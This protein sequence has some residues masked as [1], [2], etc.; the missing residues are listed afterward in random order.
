M[1]GDTIRIYGAREHN[2]KDVNLE[3][4]RNAL[5]VFCGVSGSGKSSMAFDTIYAEGQRRYVESL[6]TRARQVLGMMSRPQVDHIDGLSPAI[7][8]DQRSASGNPRSTVA[9]I[10]EIHDY[11]RVLYARLGQPYCYEC[12]LEIAAHTPQQIVERVLALPGGTKALVLAPLEATEG[13]REALKSARRAGF[14]RARVDGEVIDLADG[15]LLKGDGHKIELVVDRLVIE[16]KMRSR[17][18]DSIEVALAEGDDAVIIHVLD[19]EDLEFSTRFACPRCGITYPEMTPQMFS[20]NSPQG[21]CLECSGLGVREDVDPD[22][23][24]ADPNRSLLDGAV[25]VYGEARTPHIQHVLAGLAGH[26]GFSLE[27]AWKDLPERVRQVIFYGSGEEKVEFSYVTRA[28]RE[29]TYAKVFEGLVTASERRRQETRSQGQKQYYDR[30]Y[31]LAP[32]PACEGSRLRPESRS[33]RIGGLTIAQVAALDVESCLEFFEQ[34]DLG[35][36]G[37]VVASELLREVRA[38]LAFMKEVGVGYLTLDRAAPTLAGGEAQ[39]I[40]LA[41]Q[42]GSGLAG[43]LYILDEPSIGLHLRDQ[44]RLLKTLLDL[45][46]LGNTVIVVEHDRMTIESADHVVEFGPGAGIHGGE[47]VFAGEVAEMKASRR[48]LTGRYLTG[49]LAAPTPTHR[50]EEG[51]LVLE[52]QKASAHNLKDITVQFPLGRLICVT[53]VSGSGKST[54]VHDV[55]YLAL[56]RRLH[57][58]ADRPGPHKGLGGAQHVDKIVNI[59]QSPIGRTPRSNPATYSGAFSHIRE[60]FAATPE[61]K[62]RGYR[63]G[64]FSFN[65]K[66]GRC[67]ACQGDGV[68]K[69]EMHFLPDVYVPCEECKGA[70]YDRETLQV[71]YK[72]K[73]IAEV[74]NMTVAEALD[75][76]HNVPPIERILRTL[77]EVGLGYITL[78]QPATTVSGGEAQRLKL[79]RELSKIGTGSTLYILD[80]PTTGL[81]FADIEKL[82]EVLSRLVDAGNTVIVIEHNLDVIRMADWIIDLGPEG[83]EEGG[84]VVATGTPEELARS[85]RSHTGRFLGEVLKQH[86]LS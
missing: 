39:R 52:V 33:V 47:V 69:I 30:F 73:S 79:A 14:A 77:K 12:G 84:Y 70:R 82:M 63:P 7:A 35:A 80:E 62:M 42:I 11:L 26:Y 59:D 25:E 68:V 44:S 55:L 85:T 64:R 13:Q 2:L 9:T 86:A 15:V 50:R 37:G 4:P 19:G 8:I 53:G 40:R 20:F 76:F 27:T 57:N 16:P 31:A 48:S 29:Y 32:C 78:G 17:L 60:L 67:E 58:S 5:V 81:H 54:L 72:G 41:T 34:L 22:L 49:E 23:F 83:G 43:V 74:L 65:V 21:M 46:D 75:H 10:T 1:T 71:H 24:V 6:S 3:L 28:G 38:R 56:R 36:T 45:R 51:E 18:A 61:A 66:G